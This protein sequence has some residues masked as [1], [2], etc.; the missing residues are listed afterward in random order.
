AGVTGT[1]KTNKEKTSA[2]APDEADLAKIRTSEAEKS[3]RLSQ[4][5]DD[6]ATLQKAD[7]EKASRLS[8]VERDLA[9][10]RESEKAKGLRIAQIEAE[11]LVA[12]RE[13]EEKAASL[14]QREKEVAEARKTLQETKA[15]ASELEARHRPRAITPDQR[16]KFLETVHGQ[17]RGKVI[18]S[19]IFFN[20]E[21]HDL[22]ANILKLL[23]DA[24]FNPVE[25]APL[26]FFTT[27]R[28]ESGIRIGFKTAS[29]E[30]AH[31]ATLQK[32]FRAIGWDPPT[33]TLV[34]S[35]ADDVVEIQ[36]TPK[37]KRM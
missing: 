8:Q 12:R 23:R 24:G 16:L 7:A 15:Q 5:E 20:Q 13:A 19:A 35:D 27:S 32:A 34:N 3:S 1:Q 9:T 21:T 36:V 26:N 10:I 37:E 18:V 2:L 30:P 29:S 4:S 14:A 17:A 28:P 33:T 11:L 25:S 22:A 31:V 6:L